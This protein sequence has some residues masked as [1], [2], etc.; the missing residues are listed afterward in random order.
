VQAD[1]IPGK[2]HKILPSTH[3]VDSNM[4][5]LFDC[6][7][8]TGGGNFDLRFTPGNRKQGVQAFCRVDCGSVIAFQE[9]LS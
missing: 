3:P 4:I 5:Y 6:Q 8:Y 9:S 7:L 1:K 2:A